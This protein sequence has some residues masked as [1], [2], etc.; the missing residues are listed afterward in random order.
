MP[1]VEDSAYPVGIVYGAMHDS[2]RWYIGSTVQTL[3][4]RMG[5][6]YETAASGRCPDNKFFIALADTKPTEWTWGVHEVF[7]DIT[8]HELHQHE[9]EYQ[10]AFDSV[11]EGYNSVYAVSRPEV[12]A[13]HNREYER[14]RGAR[15]RA[16]P[17][18][19]E[20]LYTRQR[21][22]ERKKRED[23]VWR[24]RDNE[25]NRQGAAKRHAEETTEETAERKWKKREY[26][27]AYRIANKER[28]AENDRKKTARRK[29]ARLAAAPGS[30]SS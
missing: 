5:Q 8:W 15:L 17:A 1:V 30:G 20:T 13:A 7:E 9:D 18:T 4:T 23:P 29:A 16:D 24:A 3:K 26:D 25:K 22:W 21:E 2:G 11:N 10:V 19:R 28:L 6:H 12:Y 27:A 14:A